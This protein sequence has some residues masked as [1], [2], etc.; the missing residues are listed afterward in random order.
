MSITKA[1]LAEF[2]PKQDRPRVFGQYN[3]CS[4]MGFIIG[5]L[6]GGHLAEA[7]GGFYRVATITSSLFFLNFGE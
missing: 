6:I 4:S 5:P 2:T 7:D 1:L 3:A